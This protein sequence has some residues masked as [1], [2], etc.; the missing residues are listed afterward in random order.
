MAISRAALLS[1]LLPAATAFPGA[2]I[3][4][5]GLNRAAFSASPLNLNT[6]EYQFTLDGSSAWKNRN[7]GAQAR[8]RPGRPRRALAPG[9]VT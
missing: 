3:Q 9:V 6:S 7:A 4:K 8:G 5:L 2:A 1:L